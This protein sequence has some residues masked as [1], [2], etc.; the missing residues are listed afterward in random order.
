MECASSKVD[1]NLSTTA[2]SVGSGGTLI[3]SSTVT[4]IPV[5]ETITGLNVT[6]QLKRVSGCEPGQLDRQTCIL[7]PAVVSYGILLNGENIT[8]Q[9]NSWKSDSV[10]KTVYVPTLPVPSKVGTGKRGR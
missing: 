6:I 3:F 10:V 9:S 5:A 1:F 4:R 2:N 7:K 8:F